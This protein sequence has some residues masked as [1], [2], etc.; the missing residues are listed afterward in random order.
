[1][2]TPQTTALTLADCPI[3]ASPPAYLL[4]GTVAVALCRP[5]SAHLAETVVHI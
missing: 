5:G 3:P 1:M 2:P 4:L